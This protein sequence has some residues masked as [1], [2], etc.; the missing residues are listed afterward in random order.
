MFVSG[1]KNKT[2]LLLFP[3][4]RKVQ[5]NVHE[6]CI[7]FVYHFSNAVSPKYLIS[8]VLFSVASNQAIFCHRPYHNTANCLT[9]CWH[10]CLSTDINGRPCNWKGN[11]DASR[12]QLSVF[13]SSGLAL[14][15]FLVFLL[16]FGFVFSF[17]TRKFQAAQ[18]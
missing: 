11:Q 17:P 8:H 6:S 15:P 9:C 13:N 12:M 3:H 2:F 7:T 10:P 14:L 4:Q 16:G 1:K 5:A 18:I